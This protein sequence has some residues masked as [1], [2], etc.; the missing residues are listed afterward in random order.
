MAQ[1][2]KVAYKGI[3]KTVFDETIFKKQFIPLTDIFTGQLT[4]I[5]TGL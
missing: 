3:M 1:L 2:K 5:L 4:D